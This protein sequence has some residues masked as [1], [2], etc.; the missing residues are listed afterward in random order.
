MKDRNSTNNLKD[1]KKKREILDVKV[2]EAFL[3]RT[4]NGAVSF[5]ARPDTVSEEASQE[6]QFTKCQ[7]SR[8][9]NKR[10]QL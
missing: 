9:K 3:K 7:V 1:E 6:Y 8:N 4:P 2:K 5:I 10:S